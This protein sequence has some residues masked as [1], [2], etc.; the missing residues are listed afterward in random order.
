MISLPPR[1]LRT[2]VRHGRALA[3]RIRVGCGRGGADAGDDRHR[4]GDEEFGRDGSRVGGDGVGANTWQLQASAAGPA[5]A[6]K[7][8]RERSKDEQVFHDLLL[9]GSS[10]RSC[11][12][13][14]GQTAAEARAPSLQARFAVVWRTCLAF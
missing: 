12:L 7:K 1:T 5:W 10:G 11:L 9:V 2:A 14:E 8:E 13:D 6:E 3:R 4:G